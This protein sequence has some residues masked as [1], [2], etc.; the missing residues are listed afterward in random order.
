MRMLRSIT[1]KTKKDRLQN[2]EICE[3]TILLL[4]MLS[5]WFVNLYNAHYILVSPFNAF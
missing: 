4:A 5:S 3:F 2:E 1:E